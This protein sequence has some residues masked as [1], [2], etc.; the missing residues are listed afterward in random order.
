MAVVAAGHLIVTIHPRGKDMEEETKFKFTLEL[1]LEQEEIDAVMAAVRAALKIEE[2][3]V[4][5]SKKDPLDDCFEVTKVVGRH[6]KLE[7]EMVFPEPTNPLTPIHLIPAPV[8]VR[9]VCTVYETKKHCP[10]RHP[11]VSRWEECR[12]A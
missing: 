9:Y 3:T 2:K 7:Q 10:G 1:D 6:S 12:K 5:A 11:A 8:W 4:A